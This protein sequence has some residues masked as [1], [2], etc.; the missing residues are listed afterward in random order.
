MRKG[1]S[2]KEREGV[3]KGGRERGRR[4]REGGDKGRHKE[5]LGVLDGERERERERGR[6]K[7]REGGRVGVGR[8]DYSARRS[9]EG[10]RKKGERRYIYI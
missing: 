10:W 9:D 3:R 1:G 4:E 5:K 7:R 2:E 6:V 8:V